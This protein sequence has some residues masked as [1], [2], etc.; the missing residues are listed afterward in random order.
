MKDAS[1]WQKHEL[2]SVSRAYRPHI[3][4]KRMYIINGR[5]VILSPI[6][7][8]NKFLSLIVV[9]E[10]LRQLIFQAYHC[11]GVGGHMGSYKTLLILR[12]RFFWPKMKLNVFAWVQQ[13][14]GCIP[15]N[16]ARRESTGLV[17]SWP[18]ASPFAI[19][20]IDLWS[21]DRTKNYQGYKC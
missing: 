10:S 16:S 11:T 7:S 3:R 4:D 9:S 6:A 18:L 8:S 21:P 12:L 2:M 5:L 13:C 14:S 17:L 1:E 15:V 20:S 19:I